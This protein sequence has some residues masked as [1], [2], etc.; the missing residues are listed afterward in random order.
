M[1]CVRWSFTQNKMKMLVNSVMGQGILNENEYLKKKNALKTGL[2]L[3]ITITL[4]LWQL[5]D[6][7]TEQ[8]Y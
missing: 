7:S 3:K 6:V 2:F 5:N 4:P 1:R 8:A